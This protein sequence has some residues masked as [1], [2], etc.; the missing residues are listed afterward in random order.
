[1]AFL[2]TNIAFLDEKDR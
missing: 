1:M 2:A